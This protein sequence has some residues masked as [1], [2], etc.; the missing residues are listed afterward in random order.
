MKDFQD[1]DIRQQKAMTLERWKINE[2]NPTIVPANY[3]DRVFTQ[4]RTN[5]L[6]KFNNSE[7]LERHKLSKLAQKEMHNLD[8][9]IHIKENNF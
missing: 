5:K 2:V 7:C 6:N 1:M 9:P 8:I 4:W 3:F